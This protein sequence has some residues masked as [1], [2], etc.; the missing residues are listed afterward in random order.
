MFTILKQK[1]IDWSLNKRAMTV[2]EL[3]KSLNPYQCQIYNEETSELKFTEQTTPVNILVE[4]PTGYSPIKHTHK[5]VKFGVW[6]L[7]TENSKLEC[8]DEHIVINEHNQEVFVKDLTLNEKI[9]TRNGLES[10]ISVTKTNRQDY[11]Y[12]LELDDD[13]HV[14]Y[15]NNIVSHN[16][17][18]SA[19]YLLWKAM[20]NED[21]NILIASNKNKSAMEM[22]RRI[23]YAYEN[24]PFFLKPGAKQDEWNKHTIAFDN[25][26]KIDSTATSEDSGRGES[27]SLLYL[28]EFAFVKPTIQEQFWTSILPTLSTGG[29]CI[30]SSTPNGDS[31]RFA[32]LWRSALVG[33]VVEVNDDKG[34]HVEPIT[35][36]PTHIKWDQP[37]GRDETFKRQQIALL[38]ETKWLQ[39]YC[40]EFL[41]SE[42]MLI[43][44]LVLST[45]TEVLKRESPPEEYKEVKFWKQIVPG[46]T[47]LIGVDP[48]TG[49]GKDF[50]VISVFSFP[51]ME[52]VA[53]FR[54]NTMSSSFLYIVLKN[55]IR[56]LERDNCIVYFSVEN[57]GVG[58]GLISLY[59]SD[60]TPPESELVS[61]TGKDKRGFFTTAKSKL[62]ACLALKSLLE[63]DSITIHSPV[64]LQELKTYIRTKGAYAA[65]LGSTDDAVSSILVII[66]MLEEIATYEQEAHNILH[67]YEDDEWSWGESSGNDP[68]D[69]DDIPMPFVY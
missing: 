38:G 18:T 12:D 23:K 16:S 59:E 31:D 13:N 56:R 57:N 61:E 39:E 34:N 60:E 4:T 17:I 5:T 58:E 43:D 29:S 25:D 48:A 53:E 1:L 30:M 27:I 36:V 3:H 26:S 42:S 65:Q 21:V 22:I 47:Y 64:L 69:P 41:T 35:F 11:M 8:A 9:Q 14:Y 68:D 7:K 28:D 50:S 55:I 10:V 32:M 19:I 52:Q 44:P 24:L 20:Y 37:P 63:R 49:S 33:G 67:D 46:T 2:D 15:T 66:R 45:L 40:C 6:V 51:A 54:S 62:K